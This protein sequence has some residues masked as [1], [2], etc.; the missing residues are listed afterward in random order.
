MSEIVTNWFLN[1]A[2]VQGDSDVQGFTKQ[3]T[4][5]SFSLSVMSTANQPGTAAG[6]P[7]FTPA[8]LTM[9]GDSGGPQLVKGI[10]NGN[11]YTTAVV[12]GLKTIGGGPKLFVQLSFTGIY[13]T[14]VNPSMGDPGKLN[15]NPFQ[16]YFST[17]KFQFWKQQG[18]NLVQTEPI[19]YTIAKQKQD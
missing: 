3:I 18:N 19:T 15:I 12:S 14:Q 16:M 4:L 8:S 1:L 5:T 17:I 6:K 13:L 9:Q 10:I 2:G 7:V 11:P